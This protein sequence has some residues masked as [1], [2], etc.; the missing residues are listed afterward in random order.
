MSLSHGAGASNGSGEVDERARIRAMAT[1]QCPQCHRQYGLSATTCEDCDQALVEVLAGDVSSA[2]DAVH[3]P[4]IGD[5]IDGSRGSSEPPARPAVSVAPDVLDDDPDDDGEDP[6]EPDDDQVTYEMG[7]WSTQARVMLEQ[8]LTGAGV[9]RVWEGT[10]LVIRAADETTVDDLVEQVR[11]TD[12]PPLDP[13][14][15]KVVYEVA[16]WTTDQLVRLTDAL[17]EHEVGYQFDMEG[18]LVVLATDEVEVDA[19]LDA[20]L[21]DATDEAEVDGDDD[22]PGRGRRARRRAD[23]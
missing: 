16:E 9:P 10:D 7:E 20:Q 11:S 12:R 3:A 2:P 17:A 15:E 19:L 1:M 14:A 21:G 6:V 13:D 4:T 23:R 5:L 22:G 18:D 8:L